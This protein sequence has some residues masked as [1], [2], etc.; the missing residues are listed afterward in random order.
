MNFV[1]AA[2]CA[3]CFVRLRQMQETDGPTSVGRVSVLRAFGAFGTGF[4]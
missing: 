3:R 1:D 4:V 2:S